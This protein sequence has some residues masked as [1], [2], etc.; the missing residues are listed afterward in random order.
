MDLKVNRAD[1]EAYKA[2]VKFN[3]FDRLNRIIE[4]LRQQG[5]TVQKK[6]EDLKKDFDQ[7]SQFVDML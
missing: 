4:E 7:L 3:E 5:Y 1:F 6:Q 2:D